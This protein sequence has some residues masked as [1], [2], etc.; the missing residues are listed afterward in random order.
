VARRTSAS[1]ATPSYRAPPRSS[2]ALLCSAG[3]VL[4][5][6]RE[7]VERRR[8]VQGNGFGVDLGNPISAASPGAGLVFIRV[9][10]ETR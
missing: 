3:L 9:T 10:A 6:R 1:S 8:G 2:L 4:I 7:Y 5:R